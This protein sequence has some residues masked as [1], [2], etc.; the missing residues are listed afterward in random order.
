M[1]VRVPGDESLRPV[2][3]STR[4]GLITGAAIATALV[5]GLAAAFAGPAAVAVA[6]A[7]GVFGLVSW[8]PVLAT[9]L[10]LAT[11]PFLAGIERGL[12]VPLLRPNEALLLLVMSGAMA[13]GYIRAMKGAHL[14]LRLSPFDIPL[15]A[16]VLLSTVWPIS[17][18][19]L[20]GVPPSWADLAAVLPMC[21]LAG[22]LLLVRATVSTPMQVRWCIRLIIGGAVGVAAITLLQRLSIGPVPELLSTWWPAGPEGLE[23][24]TSTLS[25]AIATGDYLLIGLSL[26]VVSGVRGLV[27]RWTLGGGGLVLLVGILATAQFSTWLGAVIVGT[28]LVWRLP[29]V[30]GALLRLTPVLGVIVLLSA[31]ILIGRFRDISGG[32]APQSWLVRWDNLTYFYIPQLVHNGHFL[33]GVSPN[34]VVIPPDT[35]RDVVFLESGYLQFLWVGGVPLLVGFIALS[36]AVFRLTRR[37]ETRTDGVGACAFALATAWWMVVVLS[38]TDIHLFMRG[39]GDLIFILLG[40]VTGRAVAD[41][42]DNASE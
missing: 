4:F 3:D 26:L 12:L 9:Y 10:Y 15:A 18:M 11:L 22:L 1:I 13:G 8:R 17:S 24:G 19:L 25:N 37:L 14:P 6:A 42:A 28:L 38:L 27:S 41:R 33:L 21:K 30:R 34:S 20:R 2:A 36:M 35:A 40:V 39:V 5:A 23:R 29:A 31:P 16:F 32:S 7:A